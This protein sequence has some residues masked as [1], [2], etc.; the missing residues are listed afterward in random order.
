MMSYDQELH[1]ERIV[2]TN[3]TNLTKTDGDRP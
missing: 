1:V 3:R 2:T